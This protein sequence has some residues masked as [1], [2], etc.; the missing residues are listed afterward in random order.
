MLRLSSA[1]EFPYGNYVEIPVLTWTV[2]EYPI[3]LGKGTQSTVNGRDH[4]VPGL[5]AGTQSG[6]RA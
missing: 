4:V 1:T 6:D 5:P 3:P 2:T